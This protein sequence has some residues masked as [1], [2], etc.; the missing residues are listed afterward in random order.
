[1]RNFTYKSF[2]W[3]C[4]TIQTKR[5]NCLKCNSDLIY[6][7]GSKA[8]W[9]KNPKKEDF[10]YFSYILIGNYYSERNIFKQRRLKEVSLKYPYLRNKKEFRLEFQKNI[11]IDKPKI[12][13]NYSCLY[14]NEDLFEKYKDYLDFLTKDNKRKTN[15][16]YYESQLV[17]ALMFG[18]FFIEIKYFKIIKTKKI[19]SNTIMFK[20]KKE[21][22]E[23]EVLIIQDFKDNQ[24]FKDDFIPFIKDF[25]KI[26][27]MENRIIKKYPE[28]FL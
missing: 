8:R 13:K 26:I 24:N 18:V 20:T 2:C 19:E 17:S 25:N 27:K 5:K 3:D 10:I 14:K 12:Q 16:I 9:P 4:F 22:K 15:I 28:Y 7:I 6:V 1:M 23:F 11:D 21:A